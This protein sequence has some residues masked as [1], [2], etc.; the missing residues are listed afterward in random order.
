MSHITLRKLNSLLLLSV[1]SQDLLTFVM[2]ERPYVENLLRPCLMAIAIAALL[3]LSACTA[4]PVHEADKLNALSYHYHYRNLDS[5][6]LYAQRAMALSGDYPAGK[7]EALNNLAFVSM[8]K[9]DYARA[10]SQL[11]S[12][13]ITTAN[14]VPCAIFTA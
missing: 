11:D 7:A 1:V 13:D 4:R 2:L 5:T 12:V 14:H 9:M 3:V 10:L 8:A 6:R